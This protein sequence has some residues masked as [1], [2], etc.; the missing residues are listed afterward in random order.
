MFEG[1]KLLSRRHSDFHIKLELHC[2]AIQA[3]S[4]EISQFC[5]I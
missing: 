5:G 4:K 1:N 2:K 3:D